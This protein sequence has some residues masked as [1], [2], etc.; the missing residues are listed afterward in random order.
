V[1]ISKGGTHEKV[2]GMGSRMDGESVGIEGVMSP[3]QQRGY[4]S[5]TQWTYGLY[6]SQGL[7]MLSWIHGG[8]VNAI[9]PKS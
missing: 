7:S 5:K 4:F 1:S 6:H 9:C 2:I 3:T 8:P